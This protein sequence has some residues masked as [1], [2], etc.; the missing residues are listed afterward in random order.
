MPDCRLI[1]SSSDLESSLRWELVYR[2]AWLLSIGA[3]ADTSDSSSCATQLLHDLGHDTT[4]GS[5]SFPVF[6]T[7][8]LMALQTLCF[9]LPDT[10]RASLTSTWAQASWACDHHTKLPWPDFA[11]ACWLPTS[12]RS[13]LLQF[14]PYQFFVLAALPLTILCR[15]LSDLI[16][17]S[18]PGPLGIIFLTFLPTWGFFVVSAFMASWF[19]CFRDE[20]SDNS[21]LRRKF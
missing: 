4:P 18:Q 17:P 12:A 8:V 19:L 16:G 6:Y 2:M 20:E 3:W 15:A 5:P 14:F 13:L 10:Q 21:R 7:V 11:V 1:P 9:Q